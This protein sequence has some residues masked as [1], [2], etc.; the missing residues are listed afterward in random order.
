LQ[1]C[2]QKLIF[3]V[4]NSESLDSQ[5][6]VLDI[7]ANKDRALDAITHTINSVVAGLGLFEYA[8][9]YNV[10]HSLSVSC[11]GVL[12]KDEGEYSRVVTRIVRDGYINTTSAIRIETLY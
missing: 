2:N 9:I 3:Y 11:E 6:D 5:L 12:K 10:S 7:L 1:K 8:I 4:P